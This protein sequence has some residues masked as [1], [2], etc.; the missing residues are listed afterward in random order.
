[1]LKFLKFLISI[2]ISLLLLYWVL[3]NMG[4]VDWIY[5]P[6]HDAAAFPLGYLLFGA[7]IFGFLSGVLILWLN[8]L[9]GIF[10]KWRLAKETKKQQKRLEMLE[11]EAIM[12]SSNENNQYLTKS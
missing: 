1:M 12:P 5:S 4:E 10:E 2:P 9:P 6:L 7:F 8:A 11:D 3:A